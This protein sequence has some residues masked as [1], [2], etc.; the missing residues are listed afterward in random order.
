MSTADTGP[1]EKIERAGNEVEVPMTRRLGLVDFLKRSWNEAQQDHLA[2]FA[3]N[4]TCKELLCVAHVLYLSLVPSENWRQ[5]S[6]VR[7]HTSPGHS[8]G[9]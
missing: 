7:C 8:S 5:V 2:A 3:G 6:T 1:M 4:L 9:S